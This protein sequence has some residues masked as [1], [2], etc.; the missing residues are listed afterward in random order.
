MALNPVRFKLNVDGQPYIATT[1]WTQPSPHVLTAHT[2]LP[3]PPLAI[4]VH[5]TFTGH[6]TTAIHASHLLLGPI[7]AEYSVHTKELDA[8]WS[9]PGSNPGACL[10][11]HLTQL[12]ELLCGAGYDARLDAPPLTTAHL[13]A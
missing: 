6:Q 3:D 2:A 12:V 1:R 8:H 4:E 9:Y 5:S 13:R 11:E 10:Y 7:G